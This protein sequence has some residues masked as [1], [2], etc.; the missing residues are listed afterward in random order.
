MVSGNGELGGGTMRLSGPISLQAP[1]M[2]DLKLA[3]QQVPL[4][5]PE[6]YDTLLSGDLSISGPLSGG[7]MVAGAI[8]LAETELR[9]PEGGTVLTLPNITH[10][11]A[12]PDVVA[13]RRRAG[14]QQRGA[15][16]AGTGPVFG[17]DVSISAPRRILVRGRGLDAELGGA[18]RLRGTTAAVEPSGQFELIR[19]RLDILGKRFTLTEGLV[20]MQGAL[21]PWLRFAATTV[22]ADITATITLE[23]PATAPELRLSSVPDLP[24]DEV[25]ARLLFAR[26]IEKLSPLQAAQMAQ[27]VAQ[28]AGKGGEGL[29]GR[30][31]AAFGLDDLDLATDAAGATTLKLGKYLSDNIYT[32]VTVGDGVNIN[33]NLDLRPGLTARGTLGADGNSGIGIYYE[34]DY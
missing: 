25:L 16:Q 17:L 34:R 19:G 24:Q 27:A 8:V 4:S 13:T 2:A 5:D 1:Y 31:R 28:L 20:Q 22:T 10:V 33:L 30:L 26:G 12:P 15:A 29:M 23:G 3:L 32:D 21:T 7:A 14:L 18:L 11:G 6:L 9:V